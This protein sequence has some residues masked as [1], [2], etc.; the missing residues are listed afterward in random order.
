MK[1]KISY[2]FVT[3]FEWGDRLL[4]KMDLEASKAEL[5]ECDQMHLDN[6]KICLAIY[7]DINKANIFGNLKKEMNAI[8]KITGYKNGSD[9]P[10]KIYHRPQ[11][12]LDINIFNL[13]QT[14]KI[15]N[16]SNI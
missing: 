15:S 1:K 11:K 3:V 9:A 2:L 7:K 13:G 12:S 6:F 10:N 8:S 16:P 5:D 14:P 4:S